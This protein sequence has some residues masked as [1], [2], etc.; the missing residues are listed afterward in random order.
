MHTHVPDQRTSAI[1]MV[2]IVIWYRKSVLH[3]RR[4]PNSCLG[5]KVD[6]AGEKLKSVVNEATFQGS[7][8]VFKGHPFPPVDL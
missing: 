1:Y 6:E 4:P 8:N 2:L 3:G 7:Q 5:Y